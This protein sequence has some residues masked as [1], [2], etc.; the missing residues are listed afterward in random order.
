MKQTKIIATVGPASDKVET[1][2]AMVEQGVDVFR[3]NMSHG[4]HAY[5]KQIIENIKLIRQSFQGAKPAILVD[6]QGPKIR[7]G[8]FLNDE[9]IQLEEGQAFE[10]SLL[11]PLDE[12]T[13]TCVGIDEPSLVQDVK[14]GQE[15]LL[16]D[17][18]IVLKA[19]EKHPDR[20]ITEVVIG[21]MLSG[22]K[23]INLKGGGLSAQ[24]FTEKDYHD[25]SFAIEH[26]VDFIA[27]SFVRSLEDILQIKSIIS[28][29]DATMSVIAKIERVEAIENIEKI[30]EVSDGLMIARGDLALEVGLAKVPG[31]QK[32][33]IQVSKK[34]DCFSIVATQM[35]E[36]M[37]HAQTPTRAEVSDVANAIE[38]Q[39]DAVMLSEE[40]AVGDH[41]LKVIAHMHAICCEELLLNEK[42]Y[43]LVNNL[44]CD[45]TRVITLNGCYIAKDLMAAALVLFTE[46]GR[47]AFFSSRS[48]LRIPIFG[49]SQQIKTC[50]K[51]NIL[52]G[53]APILVDFSKHDLQSLNQLA[54]EV[55]LANEKVTNPDTVVIIKGDLV[56]VSGHT[57]AIE[58][59]TVADLL[60]HHQKNYA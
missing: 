53:V 10:L 47:T 12:G 13:Q 45:A 38:D 17:G 46:K 48:G 60:M 2:L 6:L 30:A 18:R 4:S 28:Q 41:P 8:T 39:V 7:I 42:A 50:L 14:I 40:T 29:N 54:V 59:W 25:L 55:L 20:L 51:M 49:L 33:I 5:H 35:M 26:D 32:R 56:G 43:M 57:N 31:L 58:V 23:G 11:H 21:G 3:L 52:R 22:K 9:T 36:S 1:L 27:L 34:Y 15:L 16:A 24:A 44:E 19:T 37:V